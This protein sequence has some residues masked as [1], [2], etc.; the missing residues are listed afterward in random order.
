[1]VPQGDRGPLDEHEDQGEC[2]RAKAQEDKIITDVGHR[3]PFLSMQGSDHEEEWATVSIVC[4]A[5]PGH[6]NMRWL[7]FI[8]ATNST[9][10]QQGTGWL[11]K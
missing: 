11:T 6:K 10:R 5:S 4:G 7:S 8:I 1:V 2:E 9:I 3:G